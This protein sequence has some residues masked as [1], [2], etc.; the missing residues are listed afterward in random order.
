MTEINELKRQILLM[1]YKSG[2]GHIPSAFSI[3]DILWILYNKIMV[4]SPKNP[5]NETRDRFILSKGHGCMALYVVLADLGFFPQKTLDTFCEFDSILGGHPDMNK[6]PGIEAS[7]GSLGHGLPI[8]IGVAMGLRIKKNNAHVY[9]LVGDG[10]CNEGS[11]W[12]S[13]LIGA[14]HGLTNITCVVDY[15][16]STDRALQLD[17]LAK[18]FIAFGWDTVE[19]DGHN[20]Y[21]IGTSLLSRSDTRPNAIIARTVKGHGISMLENSPA[22]HHRSPNNSELQDMLN[23]LR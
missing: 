5:S 15:N 18:K 4:V 17:S 16:R 12:E 21:E 11:I 3:L 14:N 10:E 19:I 2:E 20:H 22:W 9:V 6:V 1:S 7:T 8:A 13:L 23:A